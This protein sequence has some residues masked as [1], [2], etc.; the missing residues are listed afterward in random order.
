[1]EESKQPSEEEK[2]N[3]LDLL[4]ETKKINESKYPQNWTYDP[5]DVPM[6]N[7]KEFWVFIRREWIDMILSI[8]LEVSKS[9][10]SKDQ[11]KKGLD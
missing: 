7:D 1:M 6:R 3:F 8:E 11:D 10:E 5:K 2:K 9:E 4:T